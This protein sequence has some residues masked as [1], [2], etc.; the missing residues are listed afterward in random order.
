MDDDSSPAAGIP[1]VD[2]ERARLQHLRELRL[3]GR[4]S[5]G[6]FEAFKQNFS[7]G[8]MDPSISR[9]EAIELLRQMLMTNVSLQAKSG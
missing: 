8:L 2:L 1:E 9:Q 3:L 4:M 5:D 6:Q 7:L